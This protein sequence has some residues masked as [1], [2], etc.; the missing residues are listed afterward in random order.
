MRFRVEQVMTAIALALVGL[1][2][3][4]RIAL[5]NPNSWLSRKVDGAT[6]LPGPG[7]VR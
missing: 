7:G 3:G 5:R 6:V 1:W 4:V 2:V